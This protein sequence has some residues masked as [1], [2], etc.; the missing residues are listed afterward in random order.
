M[1]YGLLSA[2][3]I[4][5]E[6]IYKE[7]E[8]RK[9]K[10]VKMKYV[11]LTPHFVEIE[12]DGGKY[13]V[14]YAPSGQVARVVERRKKLEQL[15]FASVYEIESEEVEGLPEPREDTLYIVSRAVLEKVCRDDCICPD[16]S[17][18]VR[19]EKGN[20][21]YCRGWIKMDGGRK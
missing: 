17:R 7:W 9:R 16:T 11:N 18:S 13:R 20:I 19:D 2:E 10:E 4:E 5:E 12:K 3:E 14:A 21:L 6:K 1:E 8:K 15:D